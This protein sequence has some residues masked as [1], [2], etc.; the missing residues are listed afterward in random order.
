MNYKQHKE[1]WKGCECCNLSA[2]RRN[3][4]LAKGVIPADI[5]FIG[6]APGASENILGKPLIGPASRLLDNII[7]KAWPEGLQPV[8]WVFTNLVACIPLDEHGNKT[9]EPEELDIKACE[10]RLS[11]FI[12]LANPSAV[13]F[14][15]KLALKHADHLI[16]NDIPTVQV[17]HP[18]ALLRMDAPQKNLEIQRC[19]VALRDLA[20]DL[21]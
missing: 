11:E 12:D 6:E 2:R 18:A 1:R 3:V 8:S 5:L 13:V 15:D 9:Q 19:I 4:V 16:H 21:G 14:V 17:I 7:K 20:D 10:D